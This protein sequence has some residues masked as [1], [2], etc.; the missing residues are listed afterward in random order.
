MVTRNVLFPTH[1]LLKIV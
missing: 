1:A